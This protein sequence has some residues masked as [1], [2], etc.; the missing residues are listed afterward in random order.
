MGQ[1]VADVPSGLSRHP[2]ELKKK[3]L[4][5]FRENCET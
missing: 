2:K 1:L 5:F 3:S 4:L